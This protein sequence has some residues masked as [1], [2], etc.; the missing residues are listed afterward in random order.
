MILKMLG[1]MRS[2]DCDWE[3]FKLKECERDIC[4][5]TI[6]GAIHDLFYDL[7]RKQELH[8]SNIRVE[9]NKIVQFNIRGMT[10]QEN[11]T[12]KDV[13]STIDKLNLTLTY[14]EP[15][16]FYHG[17]SIHRLAHEYYERNYNKDYTSQMT[18]Q[19]SEV[20]DSKFCKNTGFNITLKNEE[21]THAYDFNKL[22]AY[23]LST[24][25]NDQY[26]WSQY[27][28]TDEIQPFDGVI[29]TGSYYIETNNCFPLHG[30][31]FYSDA[32]I[33]QL[34]LDNSIKPDD[35][36]YQIKASIS[37]PS[38]F[39]KDFVH[40]VA[41]IF[42]G[43]KLANNG[44]IGLLAKNYITNNKHYFT[45]DRTRAL[46]EWL[47][48][49]EEVSFLGLYDEDGTHQ[50]QFTMTET[51][52]D[53]INKAM[54]NPIE[55]MVWMINKSKKHTLYSNALPIHRKTYD[56]SNT[57]VYKKKTYVNNV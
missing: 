21:A 5:C 40:S 19:I 6:K 46:K 17:Q 31:G 55:P 26:G 30:N 43:Y 3:T 39:F 25:N 29:T 13:S 45:T 37:K 28:P 10:F 57:L 9:D 4:V 15:K 22:Y 2:T 27:T 56:V 42:N 48:K 54:E 20:F 34:L 38:D 36:K 47:K 7:L 24:C 1:H 16:Y 52:M 41:R 23:V 49:P 35:I 8:N 18:P 14:Q 12:Y 50:N 51:L 44:F 33:N 53:K 11:P 32:V